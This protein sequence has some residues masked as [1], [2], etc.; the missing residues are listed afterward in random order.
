MKIRLAISFVLVVDLLIVA[1]PKNI[2]KNSNFFL[3]NDEKQN[4]N[5]IMRKFWKGGFI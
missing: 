4:F 5:S 1:K 2:L 3:L